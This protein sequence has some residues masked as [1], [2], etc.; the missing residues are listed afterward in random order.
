MAKLSDSANLTLHPRENL[1][2]ITTIAS[3]TA[4]ATI[5]ADGSS[6]FFLSITGTFVATVGIEAS[7]DQTTWVAVPMRP[8]NA[9]SKLLTL[10]AT[11]PGQ[12]MAPHFGYSYVR[13]RCSAYTSGT[14]S[15]SLS[16]TNAPVESVLESQVSNSSATLT[17]IVAAAVGLSLPAPGVGLRQYISM[18]R[19]E[20]HAALALTAGS[21]PTVVTTANLPGSRAY[22]IPVEAAAAGTVYEKVEMF[23]RPLASSAQNTA[24]TIT[25]PITTGVIWRITADYYIAP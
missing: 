6:S 20:R 21:T 22:S 12:F 25:A 23:G 1:A 18:I 15:Y 8:V 10:S 16:M 19:I 3:A 5:R 11:A 7:N 9:A 2:L 17:G 24:V 13:L 4:G 14:V